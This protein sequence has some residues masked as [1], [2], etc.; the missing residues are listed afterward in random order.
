VSEDLP[1]ALPRSALASEPAGAA[2][3]TR[4]L[5]GI[6][7][8]AARLIPVPL[9]DDLTREQIVRWMVRG[10]LPAGIPED[11]ARPLW[12]GEGC[13]PGCLGRIAMLPITLLLFPFRKLLAVILGVRWMSRDLAEMLLLGRVLDHALAVG[14]LAE[15]RPSG[16]LAAQSREIRTAFDVA[17]RG[18]DTRLLSAI[19]GAALGPIRGI[20]RGALGVLRRLR[21]SR[22]EKPSLEDGDPPVLEESVGRIE[23]VLIQPEVRAFVAEFDRRVLENLE[24]LA[25]RRRDSGR[26]VSSPQ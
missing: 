11:A 23:R 25:A 3:R 8:A 6:L 5:A 20:V 4:I 19:L 9:V 17:L 15:G 1:R 14:L 13:L 18:T 21:R 10:T 24:V 7:Y 12:S 2:L 22:S 16:E 26:G